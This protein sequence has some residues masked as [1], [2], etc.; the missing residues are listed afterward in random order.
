MLFILATTEVHKL[1]ATILSRCQKFDFKRI[2]PES[3]A[4]HLE[5]VANCEGFTIE[6]EAAILIARIA[7]GALR[8]ALSLLDQCASRNK[9]IDA[10]LVSNVAGITERTYLFELADAINTKNTA[11]ALKMIDALHNSS[12]DME[13]LCTELINHFRNLM[14][15]KTVK[16]FEELII[17]TED[18]HQRISAQSETFTLE[19]ILYCLDVLE[20]TTGNLKRGMNK[21]V[22][23]EM[24]MV[25]LC[26]PKL[27]ESNKALLS[28]LSKLE[29]TIQSGNLP[30]EPKIVVEDK[31]RETVAE[32][33]ASDIK[34]EA[35]LQQSSADRTETHGEEKMI[36]FTAWSEV[37]MK[38]NDYNKPL[39]GMLTGS[40]AFQRGEMIVIS[41]NNPALDALIRQMSHRDSLSNA[42]FEVTG[43][44]F[45]LSMMKNGAQQQTSVTKDPLDNLIKKASQTDVQLN[46]E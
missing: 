3:I 26:S 36:P 16:K 19:T 38:L 13:R 35:K 5:Y 10:K 1:P 22:E 37:L 43:K 41:S 32:M 46:V 20:N 14:I 7:D 29:A 18:E 24:A 11:S 39:V 9:H 2:D 17:C 23:T 42:I 34:P 28:R 30:S 25:R 44:K 4:K 6:D 8:D 40:M 12:C 33:K 21:R 27:E 45:R 31:T 15:A